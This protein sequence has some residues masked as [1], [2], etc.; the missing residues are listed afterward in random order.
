MVNNILDNKKYITGGF[1]QTRNINY[2]DYAKDMANSTPSFAPK[3]FY[4]QG[5]S[6]F[7]NLQFRF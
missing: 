7:I 5:R 1:E 6:Y 3:Y 4:N 2:V